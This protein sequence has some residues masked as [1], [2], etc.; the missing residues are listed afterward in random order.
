MTVTTMYHWEKPGYAYGFT[1]N[2]RC[3]MNHWEKHGYEKDYKG[4]MTWSSQTSII[5]K[6]LVKGMAISSIHDMTITPM[7]YWK[8]PGYGKI[9][10]TRRDRHSY[11][12]SGKKQLLQLLYRRIYCD[13]NSHISLRKPWI[14]EWQCL[15]H[16]T[17]PSHSCFIEKNLVMDMAIIRM[18]DRP[19]N[20]E[21]TMVMGKDAWH[22]HHSHVSM[23]KPWLLDWL[24]LEYKMWPWTIEKTMVIGANTKDT[25]HNHNRHLHLSEPF[26]W[27]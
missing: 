10:N 3:E 24:F 20:I 19:W 1:H 11:I 15:E 4:Y 18:Q 23:R 5:K 13:H 8:N 21:K 25:L 7:Y 17:W 22:D 16:I 6:T 26:L 12:F 27:E 9:Q 2:T 14:W